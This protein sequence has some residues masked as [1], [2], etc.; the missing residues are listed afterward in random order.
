M[1]FHFRINAFCSCCLSDL[2]FDDVSCLLS[3]CP[4]FGG[5]EGRLAERKIKRSCF[6]VALFQ[7]F[8]LIFAADWY[9]FIEKADAWYLIPFLLCLLLFC[10]P[11]FFSTLIDVCKEEKADSLIYL[12]KRNIWLLS[13]NVKGFLWYF[14]LLY[15]LFWCI[16]Y[17][18]LLTALL[19][20]GLPFVTACWLKEKENEFK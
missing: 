5:K 3:I 9:L 11:W 4:L 13:K 17:D 14:C 16:Q 10:I 8:V 6:I 12:I 1:F 20:P 15:G 7:L 2:F 18:L 19:Y